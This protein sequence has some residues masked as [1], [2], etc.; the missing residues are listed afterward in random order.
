MG[1]GGSKTEKPI[2]E[3]IEDLPSI[4]RSG[5]NLSY[6]LNEEVLQQFL[7]LE[8]EIHMYE[9]RHISE[10]LQ[11]RKDQ[12]SQ[13]KRNLE[14]MES[15]YG[16]LTKDLA[17]ASKSPNGT[18][19]NSKERS[20]VK[21]FVLG[22]GK[23]DELAAYEK[24]DHLA[25]LNKQEILRKEIDGTKHHLSELRQE[26]DILEEDMGDLKELYA[27]EDKML[28]T[29]FNGDY[30]SERENKL[31]ADLD[32]LE[33]K[34][35]KIEEANFKWR[36]AQVMIEYAC[37]QIGTAVEKWEEIMKLPMTSM[38]QRYKF[39]EE[40][41]NNLIAASQNLQGAHRYLPHIRFP[42]CTPEEIVML[43][44]ATSYVFTDMQA[45]A[46]QAHAHDTYSVAHRRTAALLQWFNE[47][48]NKSI[49]HDLVTVKDKVKSV[50]LELRKERAKLIQKKVKEVYNKNIEISSVDMD[51]ETDSQ[52]NVNF[53]QHDKKHK[54]S[55]E[56]V[57]VRGSY[58]DLSYLPSAPSPIP[59]DE[60]APLPSKEDL[61]GKIEEMKIEHEKN[62]H[63]LNN[64]IH[65]QKA[66]T[67]K[68]LNQKLNYRRIRRAR[69][70]DDTEQHSKLIKDYDNNENHSKNHIPRHPHQAEVEELD[71]E[72][73]MGNILHK[74]KVQ[75]Y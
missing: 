48:I 58:S 31:E 40:T 27:A 66:R 46:R 9:T 4:L 18:L 52:L 23:Y 7:S 75:R 12:M 21:N 60:L 25:A 29:I 64:D 63:K 50:A 32:M 35:Q 74:K 13:L 17:N 57:A 30:G 11:V 15:E 61:F 10:T 14:Q 73:V 26:T 5:F 59:R 2:P 22:Q 8:R 51:I 38:E 43:N 42:Y 45:K 39:A 49:K 47:T 69:L 3:D 28:E 67:E 16:K 68:D 37:K 36:Q 20:S 62:I 24:A 54:S 6:E 1:C 33:M 19:R 53:E 34:L 65:M 41:R 71:G 55:A 56:L 44:K 72:I 70:R